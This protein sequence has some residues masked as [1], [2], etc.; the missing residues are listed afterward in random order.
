[1]KATLLFRNNL[2]V[3][4]SLKKD[5]CRYDKSRLEISPKVS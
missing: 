5:S 1:M 3:G 4:N 2:K